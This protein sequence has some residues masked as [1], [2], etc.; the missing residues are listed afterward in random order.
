MSSPRTPTARD[1]GIAPRS[2]TVI[3]RT[4]RR[5]L[6]LCL[7]CMTLEGYDIVAYGATLPSI[8][9][10]AHWGLT[11]AG[12]GLIGSLTPVGMLVGASI[13]GA[14]TDT[15]G[16]RRVILVSAVVFTV[17]ALISAAAP[18]VV[19]FGIS[20]IL[21]GVGVGA[22]VPTVSALVYE[23]SPSGRRNLN[24]ALVFAGIGIGG[25]L[26][27]T[28]AVYVLPVAGFRSVFAG[29][30]LAGIVL[31]PLVWRYLPESLM[32][33]VSV[34]REDEARSLSRRLGLSTWLTDTSV[35][36][37]DDRARGSERLRTLL[38]RPLRAT[39]SLSC[40]AT[41][42]ALLLI[43]G[44][45]TWLPVLMRSAGFPLG[46]AFTFLAILSLGMALGPLAVGS[47]ADRVGSK[48]GVVLAFLLA[49]VG[50]VS[51]SLPLPTVLM[52][53]AVATA[54][55][56]TNAAQ[57]LLNVLIGSRYPTTIRGTAVGTALSVGR[58]G[59]ISGPLLGGL[60]VNAHLQPV[61]NF[62]AIAAV[63][64]LGMLCTVAIPKGRPSRTSHLARVP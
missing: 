27:S 19:V 6:V 25:G 4:P 26:A 53:T 42:T 1:A 37:I 5:V 7:I 62:C 15:L 36:A 61:W 40:L 9:A 48:A 31:V 20:R 8:L 17:A 38:S 64:L 57:I 13:S 52:Y 56:A 35:D 23:Y 39:T 58:L 2:A 54:G 28:A 18:N 59:A 43:F 49:I 29:G 45:T 14:L 63:A 41:F 32:F 46:S 50:I 10:D 33:L 16:R 30:G 34:G 3:D 24:T 11:V 51:L 47:L 44:L 12:A 21:V 22:V 55:A 60:L